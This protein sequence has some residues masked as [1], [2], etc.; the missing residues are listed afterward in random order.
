MTTSLVGQVGKTIGFLIVAMV[1]L[2]LLV[3]WFQRRLIYF[4]LD[5]HVP[6]AASILP[7]ASDVSVTTSDGLELGAWFVPES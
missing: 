7:G 1:L 6:P 3:W 5:H 2:L 4:P